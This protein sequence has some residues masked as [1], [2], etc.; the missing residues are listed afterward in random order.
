[1]EKCTN[2]FEMTNEVIN[3]LTELEKRIKKEKSYL[4]NK[5][6][7]ANEDQVTYYE[8]FLSSKNLNSFLERFY[9]LFSSA[10]PDV[11]DYENLVYYVNNL[12]YFYPIDTS[13]GIVN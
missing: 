6:K 4:T 13:K 11:E 9:G 10:T 12:K 3:G 7:N 5:L 8:Y 2:F 1:M